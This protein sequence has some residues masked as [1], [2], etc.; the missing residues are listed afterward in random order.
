MDFVTGHILYRICAL[1]DFGDVKKA[2]QMVLLKMKATSL[3]MAIAGLLIMP[4]L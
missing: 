4:V 3:M 1:K 2:I